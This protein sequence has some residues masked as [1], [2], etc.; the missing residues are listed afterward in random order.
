MSDYGS[1]MLNHTPEVRKQIEDALMGLPDI[2]DQASYRL[3]LKKVG[4]YVAVGKI[5]VE[6]GE[7]VTEMANN[8]F[9]SLVFEDSQALQRRLQ[10]SKAKGGNE[11]EPKRL[12]KPPV[13]E[14]SWTQFPN[15]SAVAVSADE[16]GA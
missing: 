12:P 14:G 5:T 6:A 9:K 16:D 2:E 7:A 1:Y 13:F 8:I 4:V 10:D 15:P 11:P 3:F